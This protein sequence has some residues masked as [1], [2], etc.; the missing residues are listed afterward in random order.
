MVTRLFRHL[1]TFG[2]RLK[3]TFP[4]ATLDAIE[5]AIR[6]SEKSHRGEL[7]FVI[8]PALP[9][10]AV[11]LGKT[12]RERALDVFSQ[13]KVWDT[14]ENTGVLIYVLL[15]DRALEIVADRGIARKLGQDEWDR[16]A[17]DMLAEFRTGQY[18]RG[19]LS[20]IEAISALLAEHFPATADNINELPDRPVILN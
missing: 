9:A 16:I 15:A 1:T 10:V 4:A 5:A 12:S 13:L 3:S 11:M 6:T 2:W 17:R 18:E 7:R 14:E 8:E 20:G 19:A